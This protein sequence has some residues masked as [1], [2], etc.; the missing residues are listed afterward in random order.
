MQPSSAS[1]YTLFH[2]G[3]VALSRMEAT[4]MPVDLP[5]LRLAQADVAEKIRASSAVLRQHDI[6]ITQ[7]K[8][9]GKDCSLG[10]RDQLAWVLYS[11]LKLPGAAKSESGRYKLDEN[12]LLA[13][14]NDY[15]TEFL[16]LQKFQKLKTTYLDTLEREW[17][18]GR[19][20]CSLN[21]HNVKSF[22]GSADSPN[23]NNLPSRNAGIT[24]Y[25]KSVISPPEGHY[26]VEIDYSAL[27][28]HVAACYH[29]DP[30]MIDNL[31]SG[32]DIH[33]SVSKQCYRY[34]DA[35]IKG[36]VKLAKELRTAAKSDAVFSWFY[37]NYYIDVA[38]RL[39][40]TAVRTNML[41]Y[42]ASQGIKR[43]GVEYDHKEQK[44]VEQSGPDAMVTHIKA[45]EFDFW[46]V[47]YPQYDQW[48]RDW[49]KAYEQKGFF[50]TLTGF[51][52]WGAEK[53]NFVI[54]APVQGSAFHCLLQSIID[55]DAE[56]T[57]RRMDSRLFLE[58]HDSLLAI[59][60]KHELHDFVGMAK[61]IMTTKL[62]AKWP[63]LILPL[64]VETE[65]SNV[66]WFDKEAYTGLEN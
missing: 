9:F 11:H 57:K 44:W 61:E 6:Y 10:S 25:V 22:R 46:K 12:A 20:Y 14:D 64:K 13:L 8:K 24:K 56:I 17:V 48:R 38:L 63:W 5:K 42:L 60:P 3:A 47:R 4:G 33:T 51:T 49:Y 36:N 53:R 62:R 40:K 32:Y 66:S 59:V 29:R 7:R 2:R 41:D 27:E 43:L 23:L 30:T 26:L 37:G 21:L 19:V 54:N 50:E 28:V 34:D 15:V 45:V 39:W 52:W 55:I 16:R 1:A 58:I 31:N 18:D 65:I 35:W